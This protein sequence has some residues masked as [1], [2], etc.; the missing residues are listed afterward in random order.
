MEP[1][2]TV[3]S[4]A[5]AGLINDLYELGKSRFKTQLL[6]VTTTANISKIHKHI[7]STH[8]VKTIWQIDKE[9]SLKNF[10]YPSK[11]VIDEDRTPIS[12]LKKIPADTNVVIQG[13]VGQGKSIFLRYLSY[14]EMKSGNRIPIFFEL[15]RIEDSETVLC[16]IKKILHA[17]NFDTSEEILNF[18][19]DSGK[20]VLLLDG[21]DE[22]P[23]DKV[24]RI[25]SEIELLSENT[26]I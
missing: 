18:L 9:V 16:N 17:F 25:T 20:I 26:K 8:K 1:S 24:S 10:Y 22:I 19:F 2:S 7:S 12:S 11:L 5:I 14:Q 6:K 21:F 15:R 13:I 23:R 3:A 4:P